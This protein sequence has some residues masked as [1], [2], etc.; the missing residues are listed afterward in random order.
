MSKNNPI[1]IDLDDSDGDSKSLSNRNIASQQQQH[2]NNN[3][4]SKSNSNGPINRSRLLNYDD[5]NVSNDT[6]STNKSSSPSPKVTKTPPPPPPIKKR[7]QPK[8]QLGE[9][10][11]SNSN[12][13]NDN[14]DYG[15]PKYSFD[16]DDEIINSMNNDDNEQD[17]TNN[18]DESFMTTNKT[19]TTTTTSSTTNTTYNN[20]MKNSHPLSYNNNINNNINDKPL[21]TKITTNSN[22]FRN[23]ASNNSLSNSNTKNS[24]PLSY[25][26]NDKPKTTTTTTTT[27]TFK[28]NASNNTN[29]SH[30]ISNTNISNNNNN[31]NNMNN[32][33]PFQNGR[34]N[35]D[36]GA[37]ANLKQQMLQIRSKQHTDY[38]KNKLNNQQF[39][40]ISDIE[41]MRK[42]EK[43]E[44]LYSQSIQ[45]T[46]PSNQ[47]SNNIHSISN[48]SRNPEYIGRQA[49][50]Y[51][52]EFRRSLKLPPMI[53]NQ[54]IY[55]IGV[56]H[57]KNMADGK[58]P[59][60]HDGFDDR[61]KR[62][63]FQFTN[64]AENVAMNNSD[65]T[66]AKTAVDGWINSP[67]H[68][69]NLVGNFN[70]CAIG[71]YQGT[72]GNWYLTQ[73]FANSK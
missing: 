12:S 34:S 9:K 4:S 14:N 58:V 16:K 67:G 10:L 22:T 41:K 62:Y 5:D 28:N 56:E 35:F 37:S 2:N 55:L 47:K 32:N 30:P 18:N 15:D 48:T 69:K 31:N 72:N 11:N 51:S 71:V 23:N 39:F 3:R 36:Y 25:T 1:V 19:T 65:A 40:G 63:P 54:P 43:N 70:V 7:F 50:E 8:K 73:L 29:N 24:L 61:I 33:E 38:R 59:F 27:N 53:W 46:I 60:G 26:N 52:N 64:A 68:R 66:V 57:S 44:K 17:D 42:N 6:A 13:S 45:T 21:N 20:S 49:L